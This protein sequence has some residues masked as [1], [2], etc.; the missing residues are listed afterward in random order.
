MKYMIYAQI[1][2]GNK[3]SID[4]FLLYWNSLFS[5]SIPWSFPVLFFSELNKSVLS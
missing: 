3:T 4:H 5:I 1:V 2:F